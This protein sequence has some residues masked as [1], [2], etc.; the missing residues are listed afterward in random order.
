MKT[1]IAIGRRAWP[2]LLLGVLLTACAP[3]Y[4]LTVEPTGPAGKDQNGHPLLFAAQDSVEAVV[5]FS[6]QRGQQVL[7]DVEV[8]NGSGRPVLVDPAQFYYEPGVSQTVASTT[9]GASFFL[10]RVPAVDPEAQLQK[11]EGKLATEDRKATGTSGWE[12]LTMI[13]DVTADLTANKRKET[14]KQEYERKVQYDQDMRSYDYSRAR[15]AETAD[16]TALEADLW[17]HKML[18]RYLL[19]PGELMRGYVVFPVLDQS[20]L[21]LLGLPIGPH[22]FSFDFSQQRRRY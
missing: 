1:T 5:S 16:R 17:Q 11:L 22:R 21:L 18:H 9:A 20:A 10:A 14:P 4:Y 3:S 12:W 19:Q 15:H 7:F 6:H 8:R 2:A 13:S